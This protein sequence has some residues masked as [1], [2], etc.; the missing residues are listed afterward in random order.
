MKTV[1][2]SP[3]ENAVVLCAD[4]H[5]FPPAYI[6]CSQL[7]RG[8]NGQ[9]AVHLLTDRGPHLNR[10]PPDVGFAIETPAFAD[11][12]PDNPELFRRTPPFGFLR[13]FAAEL[14]SGYRRLLYIDSD[15]RV[16]GS[17]A[18]LF[19][20]NL[21]GNVLAA[22]GGVIRS[23]IEAKNLQWAEQARHLGLDAAKPQFN[24]GL[25]LIDCE[26]WRRN[27]L[28]QAA[29]DCLQRLGAFMTGDQDCLNVLLQDAWTPL[30]PRWN[31]SDRFY[32]PELEAVLKPVIFHNL[33]KPWH[34][35]EAGR[36]ETILFK[37]AL[38]LTPYADFVPRIPPY[39]ELKRC[40]EQRVK[41]A[42]VRATPFLPSSAQRL[43][44]RQSK[45]RIGDF[46]RYVL[47]NTESGWF[48]DVAQNISTF[49]LV[50]LR[51]IVAAYSA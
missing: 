46:A 34:F 24:S 27:R 47:E 39:R 8:S 30:S 2:E 45:L 19:S 12:L 35:G 22:V 17:I 6:V 7:A 44:E 26:Q 40:I 31:F 42:L 49:D 11:R 10:V 3:C 16:E 48:A 51:R 20:L 38:A 32:H 25:L 37:K 50:Q 41:A 43:R 13:L 23:H 33:Q 28:T 21:E 4:R 9:Y 14:L 36:R 18:P 1:A 15:M 29:L 5:Y